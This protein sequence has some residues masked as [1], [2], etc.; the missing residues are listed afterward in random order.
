M[1]AI[2]VPAVPGAVRARWHSRI[3]RLGSLGARAAS[4][5]VAPHKASLV[6]LL[7]MPLAVIGTGF[8]DFSAFHVTHALGWLV[9]GASLWVVEHLIADDDSPGTA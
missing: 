6:R 2:P 8:I 5:A 9:T 3:K 7:D 1:A 4:A